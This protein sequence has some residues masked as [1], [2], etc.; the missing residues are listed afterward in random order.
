MFTLDELNGEL[1]AIL[2]ESETRKR[3]LDM[4]KRY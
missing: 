1:N 4:K 3:L 2:S